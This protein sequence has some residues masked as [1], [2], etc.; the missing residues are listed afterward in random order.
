MD[1][2]DK[3]IIKLVGK[4]RFDKIEKR[5][6]VLSHYN[7]ITKELEELYIY[8]V[9][10]SRL[11]RYFIKMAV[12]HKDIYK[13]LHILLG[14]VNK[15]FPERKINS[16]EFNQFLSKIIHDKEGLIIDELK[17]VINEEINFINHTIND[18]TVDIEN[19]NKKMD[20]NEEVI[21]VW[22]NYIKKIDNTINLYMKAIDLFISYYMN[23]LVISLEFTNHESVYDTLNFIE[24][25]IKH[26]ININSL[27][28][29]DIKETIIKLYIEIEKI[30]KISNH[31]KYSTNFIL[32]S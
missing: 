17:D 3:Y 28:K 31:I 15:Y 24:N 14:L 23:I 2:L 7:S 18:L 25:N 21:K 32:T 6:E 8:I 27:S 29:E 12:S 30:K 11:I 10:K 22:E 5:S 19:I 1:K 4:E 26:D 9:R 13:K 20:E 16:N